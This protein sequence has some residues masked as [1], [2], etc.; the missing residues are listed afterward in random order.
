[1]HIS[2]TDEMI[3]ADI[4]A[5]KNR[6]RT[7]RTKLEDLS[8]GFLPYLEYKKC[9]KK[10]NALNAEIKHVGKLILIA[11]EGFINCKRTEQNG[12]GKQ[13]HQK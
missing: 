5:Y 13:Q 6:I 4:E 8:S 9:E 11:G 12:S 3:L 7:A 10:R 1:M 2:L